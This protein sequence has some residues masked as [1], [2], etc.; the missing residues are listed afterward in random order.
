METKITESDIVDMPMELS[1]FDPLDLQIAEAKAQNES[2][3]FDYDDK[4]GNKDARSWVA[5]LR[6]L[7]AP[8]I[9]M[10]KT[11]KAEALVYC[12]KWDEAK[13]KRLT[14]IEGM[15]EFHDKPLR[16]IKEAE[17][18]K[19]ADEEAKIKAEEE[20]K[21][22]ASVAEIEAAQKKLAE[23]Q[24]EL[25]L[26]QEAF[27]KKAHEALIAETAKRDAEVV[28]KQTAID[29]ENARQR[30]EEARALAAINAEN[31]RKQAIVD[32]DNAKAAAVL[33]AKQE[34]EAAAQEKHHQIMGAQR[35]EIEAR[36]VEREKK[37]AE[38]MAETARINNKAHR[39]AVHD[40][41]YEALKAIPYL[42]E[43][44]PVEGGLCT[45]EEAAARHVFMAI[46]QKKIPHTHIKY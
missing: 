26:K 29:A 18:K 16:E 9:E 25:R 35:E 17:A 3:A 19:K 23:E 8:V 37:E 12:K 21:E 39:L 32:A 6:T 41:I 33:N 43:P 28:A 44:I 36:Q 34:A 10:H 1:V 46:L 4:Q 38:E 31:A 14:A 45:I 30:A 40:A 13:N 27:D 22:A 5:K 2:L 42:C 15:I 24:E 20:A 7:K 11:G